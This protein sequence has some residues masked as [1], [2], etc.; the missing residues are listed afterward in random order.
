MTQKTEADEQGRSW[1]RWSEEEARAALA[2]LAQTAESA[3]GFARRKGISTQRLQYWKKRLASSS[4]SGS[5][6]PAFVAVTMPAV[7]ACRP[8]MEI[9]VGEITVVV[10]EGCDVEQVARLVDAL[11]RRTRAC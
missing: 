3:V 6:P 2:E 9:R 4:S 11:S 1:R 5:A 7:A 10:R 8:E